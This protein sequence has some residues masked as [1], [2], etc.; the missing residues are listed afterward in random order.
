MWP[1]VGTLLFVALFAVPSV[2]AH[3]CAATPEAQHRAPFSRL[4]YAVYFIYLFVFASMGL[5]CLLGNPGAIWFLLVTFSISSLILLSLLSPFRLLLSWI[6]SAVNA[7]ASLNF[8]FCPLFKLDREKD[9]PT[10]HDASMARKIFLPQSFPHLNGWILFLFSLGL[11]LQKLKPAGFMAPSLGAIPELRQVDF[12]MMGDFL[13]ALLVVLFGVGIYVTRSWKQ[14]FFRLSLVKPGPKEF[15]FGLLFCC[16]TF[17]Y[18]YIWSL[19]THAP[20]QSGQ[21]ESIMRTFNEGSYMASGDMGSALVLSFGIGLVAGIEEEI[22]N[23]GALQ[24]VLG[25]VP[26]AFL[27]AAL[28]SQFNS[29]PLFILQIFGWSA[30]MG[31]A[32]Y[33]TNTTTTIIAHLLFNLISC[34][35]IGFNP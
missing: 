1:I 10:F 3:L 7:L 29:A 24:P 25:I 4:L 19:F 20:Q 23:R 27:H 32:K 34:F 5:I 16:L 6:F 26:A 14:V 13:S 35:I 12:S 2:L 18:D 22:T 11:S 8:I 15:G 33:Y 30:L 28:H 9:R 17:A 31:T 21:Y